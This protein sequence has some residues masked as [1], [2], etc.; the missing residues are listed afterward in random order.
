MD[1]ERNTLSKEDKNKPKKCQGITIPK[2]YIPLYE[3]AMSGKS[4]AAGVKFKCMDCSQYSA[5]EIKFCPIPDCP[6]YPYRPYQKSPIQDK[7]PLT[8]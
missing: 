7:D 5:R 4:R 3:K 1:A 2:K 8:Y 6:L